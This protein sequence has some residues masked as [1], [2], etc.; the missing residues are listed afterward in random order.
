MFPEGSVEREE[1]SF[2]TIGNSVWIGSQSIITRGVT[3]GDGAIIGAGSV[4]T[5]DV[6][7]WSVAVG[8]PARVVKT[9]VAEDLSLPID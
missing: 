8:N 4:V 5:R 9:L 1:A 2:V 6:P 7:A 3:I